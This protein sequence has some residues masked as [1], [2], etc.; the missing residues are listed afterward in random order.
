MRG[1]PADVRKMVPVAAAVFAF[2]VL[3]GI[4]GIYFDIVSPLELPG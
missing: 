2:I 4:L 1:R 3:L